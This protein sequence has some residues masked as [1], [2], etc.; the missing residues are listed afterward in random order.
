MSEPPQTSPPADR[1]WWSILGP[2]FVVAATGVGAGDLIAAAV[3]GTR[4][5]LA[6]LWVVLLGALFKWVLN[7]GIARWQ[8]AT[9]TTLIAGWMQKLPRLVTG[10]FVAFLFLWA[11]LVAGTLSNWC[12]VAAATLLPFGSVTMWGVVHALIGFGLVWGGRYET[13]ERLMK[14]LIA[15]MFAVVIAC[16]VLLQPDLMAFARGLC[17]PT[18]PEGSARLLLGVMGGV[19]GSVTL[20]CYGYWIREKGWRGRAAHR[21]SWLDLT[22]AYALTGIFGL[23]LIVIASAEGAPA[24]LSGAGLILAL[25]D[26]LGEQLGPVGRFCFLTGFWCAVFTSLLGVWHGVPYLF[27]DTLAHLKRRRTSVTATEAQSQPL[28]RSAAY[29]GFLAYLAFPPLLLL[30][31]E[32]PIALAI[33]YAV[34]GAFFMPFLATT[35]LVLNNRREWVGS[36]RNN[37]AINALLALSL[38]LFGCLFVIEAI[39]T[40]GG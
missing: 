40:L 30:L 11:F 7:E 17:T 19:G 16:A 4:F 29:R 6:I 36:L 18:I 24:D 15:L 31:V 13:F 25:A 23:A 8:L 12:G 28:R 14:A 27:A 5:G 26:R 22:A 35:L 21:R 32:R 37:I 20:L 2:G 10:Y 39:E 9:G 38:V 1:R 3:A 34:T 33:A